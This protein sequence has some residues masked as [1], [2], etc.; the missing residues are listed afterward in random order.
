ML[1]QQLTRETVNM[2]CATLNDL[3]HYI[4]HRRWPWIINFISE[5]DSGG[6][7]Y[8]GKWYYF[9]F[10]AYSFKSCIFLCFRNANY[11]LISCYANKKNFPNVA[12]VATKLN[13]LQCTRINHKTLYS[14]PFPGPHFG[15]GLMSVMASQ[16]ISTVCLAVSSGVHQ[17]KQNI[18]VPRYWTLWGEIRRWPVDFPH[19]G[20][21]R[22]KCCHLM[23][24]SW[25]F[26]PH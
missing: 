1:I 21:W 9:T 8:M 24:S 20:Q 3:N 5:M 14:K 17:R 15:S 18:K 7:N 19:K 25:V 16:I 6:Q 4:W 22:R 11:M 13:A 26:S 23:T 12:V 2:A 10:S